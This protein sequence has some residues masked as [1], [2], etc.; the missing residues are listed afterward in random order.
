MH[1]RRSISGL[2]LAATLGLAVGCGTTTTPPTAP[3]TPATITDTFT[4]DLAQQGSISNNFK[5]NATGEV[6]ITL[7]SVTPLATMSLGVGMMTS[8][9]TNCTATLTQ[10]ADARAN[11]V[12]ALQ[13]TAAAGSYCVRV[14]DSGNIP[15]STT[16]T[17]TVTVLHP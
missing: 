3:S 12:A 5:V 9:G 8:D 1:A 16:V 11:N 10:N 4:A 17:Y 13:G 2:M 6:T 7:T 14:F 15:V